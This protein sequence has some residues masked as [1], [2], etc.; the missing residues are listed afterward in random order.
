MEADH[1]AA[2]ISFLDISRKDR[3][4]DHNEDE[5]G[6]GNRGNIATF[7]PERF[8]GRMVRLQNVEQ[9]RTLTRQQR[10]PPACK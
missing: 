10:S 9:R 8:P 3:L 2:A 7:S 6:R 5:P 1:T 4:R